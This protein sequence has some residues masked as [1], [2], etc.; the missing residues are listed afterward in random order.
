L[1]ERIPEKW[2]SCKASKVARDGMYCRL[3]LAPCMVWLLRGHWLLGRDEDAET[4]E[5]DWVEG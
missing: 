3:S 1:G 4:R 2:A 5:R